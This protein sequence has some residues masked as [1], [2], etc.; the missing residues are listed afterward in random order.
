MFLKL[1]SLLM[2]NTYFLH[3]IYFLIVQTALRSVEDEEQ[4]DRKIR[5]I[6]SGQNFHD[7]NHYSVRGSQRSH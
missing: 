6:E 3:S 7:L 1:G 5:D 4:E 2:E